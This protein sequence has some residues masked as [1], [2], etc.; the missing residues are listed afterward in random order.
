MAM[1]FPRVN[2]SAAGAAGATG[3][4][5][6]TS[7][8]GP[9]GV[10]APPADYGVAAIAVQRGANPGTVWATYSARLVF[11]TFLFFKP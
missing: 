9:P 10:D 7:P 6:P 5:G 8:Q 1:N 3:A 11:A 2:S 4:T